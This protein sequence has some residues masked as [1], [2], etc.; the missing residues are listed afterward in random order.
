MTEGSLPDLDLLMISRMITVQ[1]VCYH[2]KTLT[3]LTNLFLEHVS[4]G[5]GGSN[6]SNATVDW[7]LVLVIFHWDSLRRD[8]WGSE[9]V[10]TLTNLTCCRIRKLLH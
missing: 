5:N 10:L 3:L 8:V 7:L 1:R 4:E 6:I 9:S 2:F